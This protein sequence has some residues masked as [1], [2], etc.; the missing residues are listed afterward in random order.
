MIATPNS[1]K[2][3]KISICLDMGTNYLYC[4]P[5]SKLFLFGD[6]HIQ[7]PGPNIEFSVFLFEFI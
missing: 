1:K 5:I 4:C 6:A 2:V 7:Y 3:Y